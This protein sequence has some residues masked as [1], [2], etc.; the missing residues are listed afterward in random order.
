MKFLLLF[1]CLAFQAILISGNGRSTYIVHMDKSLMPEAFASH[2]LWYSNTIHSV[3]A[4]DLE[5][6]PSLVYT[7]DH[8]FHGFSALL[9]KD[10]L[11][12]LKKSPGFVSAYSDK[13]VTLDTTHTF[14]FLSLNLVT[15]LWPASDYGKD[16]IIG[17][18]DTGIWPESASFKDDGM[19]EVP[20]RWKGTCEVGQEFNASNCNLKLIGA[21]YFNKGVFAANPNITLSM[22]S[23]R[24]TEGHGTHTS[25]TAGGNY[26]EGASYFGYAS[27]TARGMA[28]KARLAM[29]K[30]IWDEGRYASDVLAGMD[31]A[32]ADG[33]DIISISMGFDDMPLYEDPIAIASFG[34]MERGVLVSSSAGNAGPDPGYLHN[35]IPWVLTVAAGSIDRTLGGNLILGNELSLTGWTMFPAKA[36]VNDIP[37]FYDKNISS[38]DSAEKLSTVPANAIIMLSYVASANAVAGVIISDD[39]S[40]FEFND[41]PYPGIVITPKQ[42]LD[43]IKYA[44]TTSKPSATITFQQTFVGTKPAPAVAAYTS[45]GPSSSYPGILKPDIMAPGTLVLAAWNPTTPTSSIGAN[46][47]LSSDYTAVSGTSMSCPHASGLAALLKGAHPE[48]S[49]AAIRSAMMTTANPLDNSQHQIKDIGSDFNIATP[50]SMGAGQVDPNRALNPGLIYDA[51]TQDYV[52]LLCS[53][54]FTINQ[55]Y[56]ITR[57]N[58][59][60]SSPSSDLNYPSF[61]SLYNS[62]LATGGI[63]TVQYYSRTVTNVGDGAATYKAKV[64]APKGS[65]VTVSPDTLVF[66]KMYEKL[67]YSVA[68][69]FTGDKNGTVT[70]GS[71][72]WTDENSKYSVRS[73]IVISPMVNAW[74]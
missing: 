68:I 50:L 52:N 51:T 11:E 8:A 15:G 18:I 44:Q 36:L 48:W 49:P 65:V 74:E 10:E 58:I 70:F 3:K 23:A 6:S 38:C 39:Q 47:Q 29:Y 73:P 2:D 17:V 9:S 40:L 45:R 66:G 69:A 64:S 21:R 33:V 71:L 35:G 20:S 34:A 37:L 12:T 13:N 41:F 28:P 63:T 62:T 46:I 22:N 42:G 5:S 31:Q 24:D 55:I 14:E 57:T 19:S 53:M 54:N 67:S 16:V 43:V 25:S 59:S 1:A 30:V 27:G 72:T 60:C 7:Y 4:Q 26:V 56:T 61:I 32:V